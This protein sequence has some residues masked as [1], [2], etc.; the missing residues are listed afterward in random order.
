MGRGIGTE[1]KF[2]TAGDG[3]AEECFAVRGEFGDGLAVGE[4]ILGPVVYC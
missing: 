1:E 4:G 3:G 2:G